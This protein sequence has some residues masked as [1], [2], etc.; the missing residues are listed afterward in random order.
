MTDVT[1]LE[2]LRSGDLAM[3]GTGPC[4]ADIFIV[5]WFV[6]GD[7]VVDRVHGA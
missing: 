7:G 6:P 2:Q 3:V 1:K 4:A 5:M